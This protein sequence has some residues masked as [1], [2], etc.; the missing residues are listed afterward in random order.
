VTLFLNQ[1]IRKLID[2]LNGNEE[3]SRREL[4]QIGEPALSPLIAALSHPTSVVRIKVA[5]TLAEFSDDRAAEA[6]NHTA[7]DPYQ[8]HEVHRAAVSALGR[9]KSP[10]AV[11]MLSQMLKAGKYSQKNWAAEALSQSWNPAAV[12]ALAAALENPAIAELA[13]AQETQSLAVNAL[14]RSV[15]P[16]A[17]EALAR[18][19]RTGNA[20]VRTLAAEALAK[21][22]QPG[23]VNALD[24]VLADGDPEARR[25]AHDT[26]GKKGF[27]RPTP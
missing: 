3:N 21:S 17:V 8:E 19:L 9:C 24:A 4:V 11:F 13:R 25:L 14:G 12:E 2:Q 18:A 20:Y 15:S 26:L 23:V 10:R 7:N 22:R 16:R 6:L 1:K 5:W 27:P